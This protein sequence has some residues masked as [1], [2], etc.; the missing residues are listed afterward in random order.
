MARLAGIWRHPL[1]GVGAARL[2]A[3]DLAAGRAMP[4]DRVFALAHG[5]SAWDADAPDWQP[6]RNFVVQAHVPELARVEAAYDEATGRLAL[7]HPEAGTV[8]LTLDAPGGEAALADWIAPL[9]GD[10]QPGPYRLA[11]RPDGAMTDMAPPYVSV[12]SLAS[13][14]ALSRHM[15]GTLGSFDLGARR[16]R[17]NL[18]LD[19]LDPWAEEDWIGREIAVGDVRLRI[20][21]PIG[22]CRATEAGPASG[23]YDAATVTELRRARGHTAFGVYATVMRGGRIATGDAA[24]VP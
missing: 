18:W 2:D 8:R 7:S 1:K 11:H 14:D 4:F 9:A 10:R 15:G 19:D 21:E 12:L 20:D 24:A 16:F 13:L 17:G 6:R 23:R 5:A 22:R 3:V